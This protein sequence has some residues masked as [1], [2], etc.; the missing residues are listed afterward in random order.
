METTHA[1]T[2]SQRQ[3]DARSQ[4]RGG[5]GFIINVIASLVA[6]LIAAAA[7]FFAGELDRMG[8]AL[9]LL[10]V[11][12]IP[13]VVGIVVGWWTTRSR[14]LVATVFAVVLSAASFGAFFVAMPASD[15][16]FEAAAPKPTDDDPA[17]DI[18]EPS[19]RSTPLGLEAA[20]DV[21]GCAWGGN[22]GYGWEEIAPQFD[23]QA[24]TP[25]GIACTIRNSGAEGHL[26]FVVPAEA[27]SL[28][29]LAG[30]DSRSEN[31]TTSLT[32]AVVDVDGNTLIERDTAY[33]SPADIKVD[34]SSLERVRLRVRVADY[35]T[36]PDDSPLTAAWGDLRFES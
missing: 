25:A 2:S 36:D 17:A 6:T 26:D 18:A 9:A 32:F 7:S 13:F 23:K 22:T 4:E 20:V 24:V 30:V 8:Q 33:G 27:K 14:G 1:T 12:T 34:V 19:G 31:A 35:V 5:R 21:Q 15:V 3:A 16:V 10:A 28:H 11:W 29:A